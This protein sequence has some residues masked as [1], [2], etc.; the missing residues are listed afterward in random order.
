MVG[1]STIVMWFIR[2]SIKMANDEQLKELQD[3]FVPSMKSSITGREIE[4]ILSSSKEDLEKLR[5][6]FKKLE[7]YAHTKVHDINNLLTTKTMKV[8]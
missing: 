8:D 7:M 5:D 6:D 4:Q 1:V 3:L 2:T